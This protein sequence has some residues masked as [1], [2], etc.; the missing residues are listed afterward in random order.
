MSDNRLLN[1]SLTLDE[2]VVDS[3]VVVLGEE[4]VVLTP[5]LSVLSDVTNTIGSSGFESGSV[6]ESSPTT[7]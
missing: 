7:T 1:L 5:P 4:A 3:T 2:T 6:V